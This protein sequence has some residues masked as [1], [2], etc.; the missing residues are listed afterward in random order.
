MRALYVAGRVLKQFARDR[1]TLGLLIFAPLLILFLAYTILNSTIEAPN[2][3]QLN[4]PEDMAAAFAKEMNLTAAAGEAEA[5]DDLK[6]LKTDAV[7]IYTEPD[8]TVCLEGSDSS[9]TAAVKKAVASAMSSYVRDHVNAEALRKIDEQK[10]KIT[11]DIDAQIKSV[12]D[13][14]TEDIKEQQEKI[15][16]DI[17][18][19][20]S[21]KFEDMKEDVKDKISSQLK[22]ALRKKITG[23][24]EKA[25]AAQ[26]EAVKRQLASYQ[27][28]VMRSVS[29]AAESYAQAVRRALEE[30]LS[31]IGAPGGADFQMPA[32]TPPVITPPELTMPAMKLS[33]GMPSIDLSDI[34]MP[35]VDMPEIEAPVIGSSDIKVPD[36]GFSVEVADISYSYL[37]G[38][39]DMGAFDAA[40]PYLMGFF[41]FFFVFIIAGIAFLR[42]R[43]S[44]TLERVL[45]TPIRRYEIVA[46]YFLGF[47]AFAFVQTL[48]IQFFMLYVLGIQIKGSLPLICAVNL[49]LATGSLSLGTF[50]SAFAR[51]EMQMFQFIPVVI[52]PQAVFC[53]LFSLR[54]A[55]GWVQALS[56]LFPLTYGARALNDVAARG[57]GFPDIAPDMAVL[58]GFT[59]LF[60]VLNT[61]VLKKYRRM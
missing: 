47:G 56:K 41:V 5:L 1:R 53:G 9:L 49:L 22:S 29:Q 59:L 23:A 17:E 24:V 48:L 16:S 10:R 45:A 7:I 52:V 42:E 18:S 43:I 34:E 14:V 39:D 51:N 25:A 28:G 33:F 4:M 32:F 13:S 20:M 8:I 11:A 26:R 50:L 46:G 40:A 58:A 6:H 60:L 55:P 37:N 54:D 36:I 12:Q 35:S 15:K 27:Q 3:E 30:Y 31:E 57:M 44:G 2:V 19:R 21:E 38:S 61:L